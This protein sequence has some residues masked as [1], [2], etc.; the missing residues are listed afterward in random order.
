MNARPSARS[1]IGVL[2]VFVAATLGVAGLVASA[3]PTPGYAYDLSHVVSD[4]AGSS[5]AKG[6]DEQGVRTSSVPSRAVPHS[7][8]DRSNLARAD[9][10]PRGYRLA[11]QAIRNPVPG[12]VAR[13]VDARVLDRGAS[14][15]GA[16]GADDVFVTGADDI[17][18]LSSSDAIAQ[19]LT[20][21]DNAVE[22]RSGPFAVL[23]FDTP[24]GIASP[25]FRK[26]P[27]FVG[28]GRTAGGAREFVTPNLPLDELVNLTVRR[29]P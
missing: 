8:D 15:L 24:A 2:T 20:I 7:Y 12:R 29:A 28:S 3:M 10:R 27:G 11:P 18:G 1:V 19:Q 4:F 9:A 14:R 22:L 17:A 5:T 25:V 6:V 23:E 21:L 26:N 16:P 13:V